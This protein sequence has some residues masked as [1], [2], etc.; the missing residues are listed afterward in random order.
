MYEQFQDAIFKKV[1]EHLKE[2]F[3]HRSLGL[4]H[5]NELIIQDLEF[6]KQHNKMKWDAG[7]KSRT[8][9]DMVEKHPIKLVIYYRGEPVGYAFGGYNEELKSVEV[10]WME[11]RN[12]AH[13]D[14]DHQMLGI[15]LDTY[16][17]YALFLDSQGMVSDKI[18]MVSPVEGAKAYYIESGFTFDS[19]YN[20]GASAM[21]LNRVSNSVV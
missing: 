9:I 8:L 4:V 18:A 19:D 6:L 21:I 12:D 15:V 17:T 13:E 7:V 20:R 11:K 14:L 1:A 5:P 2:R 16:A 3:P 10:H